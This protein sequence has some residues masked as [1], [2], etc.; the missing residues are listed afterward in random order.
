MMSSFWNDFCL[1]LISNY[2]FTLLLL[3][4]LSLCRLSAPAGFVLL[5]VLSYTFCFL[6][7]SF[8]FSFP[9][10]L[11]FNGIL[12]TFCYS[13][14]NQTLFPLHICIFYFLNYFIVIYYR[15]T[16]TTFTFA[17]SFLQVL[18]PPSP[19]SPVSAL[20][21]FLLSFFPFPLSFAD[22]QLLRSCHQVLSVQPWLTP[23]EVLL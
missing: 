6:V 13:C 1:F 17:I 7:H 18:S 22:I 19:L 11:S 2:S 3:S 10:L 20:L 16:N 14:R 15:K 5:V 9:F 23:G 4:V 12:M 21:L 8:P